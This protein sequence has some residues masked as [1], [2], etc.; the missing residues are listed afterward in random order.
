MSKTLITRARATAL[1]GGAV[2]TFAFRRAVRAQ[3]PDVLRIASL[4]ADNAA[5]VYYASDTGAFARVGLSANIVAMQN[6][7]AIAAA[8]VSGAVDIGY[9][10]V[11]TLA[12]LHQKGISLVVIAP[13]AE[14]L[15]PGS[16]RTSALI[17][18]QNSP[19]REARDLNGKIVATPG[20]QTLTET[21]VRAWMDHH[22]GDSST[23]KFVELPFPAMPAALEAGRIDAAGVAEPFL[24]IASRSSRVV[25]YGLP[26]AISDRFIVGAW[27][28]TREFAAAHADVVKRFTSAMLATAIWANKNHGQTALIVEKYMKLDSSIAVTMARAYYA[29]RLTAPLM[30]PLIDV[31]AKYYGFESFPAQD[32]LLSVR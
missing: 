1:L 3:S 19:I 4:P 22:G 13:A 10:T 29:E 18:P 14:Y 25:A 5:A 9:S 7:S 32:L 21:N 30:Q 11:D 6:G 23:V 15:A 8:V 26:S 2:A 24:S 20:L 28:T 16:E 12:E 17:V 27:F 31:S